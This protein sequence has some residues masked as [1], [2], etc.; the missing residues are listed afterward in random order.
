MVP[1][2]NGSLDVVDA[3]VAGVESSCIDDMGSAP[4]RVMSYF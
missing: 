4:V 2:E 3:S 1:I